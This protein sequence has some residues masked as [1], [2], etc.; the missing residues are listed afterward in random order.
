MTSSLKQNEES[1]AVG[2]KVSKL[3]MVLFLRGGGY[4]SKQRNC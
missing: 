1:L 4:I 3:G 2:A